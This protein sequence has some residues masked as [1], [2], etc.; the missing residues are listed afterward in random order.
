MCFCES[1]TQTDM[2]YPYWWFWRIRWFWKISKTLHSILRSSSRLRCITEMHLDGLEEVFVSDDHASVVEDILCRRNAWRLL[3]WTPYH[4]IPMSHL[5]KAYE[6]VGGMFAQTSDH[7][8][9]TVQ[10]PT[11]NQAAYTTSELVFAF[12]VRDFAMDPTQDV[13]ALLEDD[14]TFV[15]CPRSSFSVILTIL[16]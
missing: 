11:R 5:C 1:F 9:Q 6:L 12:V 2:M 8:L 3:G 10:L 14:N 16:P 4:S 15:Q 7:V 13:M